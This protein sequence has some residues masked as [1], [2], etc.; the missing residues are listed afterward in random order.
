MEKI[1]KFIRQLFCKHDFKVCFIHLT[2]EESTFAKIEYHCR[3][4]GKIKIINLPPLEI[5]ELLRKAQ[6]GFD[7]C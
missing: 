6:E 2:E 3:K 7:Y 4:C 5:N 1:K